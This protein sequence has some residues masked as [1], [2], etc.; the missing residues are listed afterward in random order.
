MKPY[1][2]TN[3]Q[4]LTQLGQEAYPA[5][6]LDYVCNAHKLATHLFAGLYRPSGKE[7]MAHAVGTASILGSLRVPAKVVAA[8]LLCAAYEHGDFGTWSK[9]ISRRKRE[10][11]KLAVGKDVEEYVARYAALPWNGKTMSIIHERTDALERIDRDVVL[12][13]LANKLEDLSDLGPLYCFS[14]ENKRQIYLRQVPLMIDIAERLGFLTLGRELARVLEETASSKVSAEL[15]SRHEGV[16]LIPPR[17]SCRRTRV[18][19]CQESI[20]VF[21]RLRSMTQVKT[22]FRKIAHRIR[23]GSM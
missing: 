10:R 9:G 8:G 2:Q 7:F 5:H 22:R 14:A 11:V 18:L 19:F 13:R 1:A 23:Q 6:E 20:R 3:I 21:E 4:L 12:L 17:S 15:R 16:V